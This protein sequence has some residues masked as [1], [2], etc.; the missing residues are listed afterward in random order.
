MSFNPEKMDREKHSNA[1]KAGMQRAKA[2]GKRTSKPPLLSDAQRWLLRR[3]VSEQAL[4]VSEAA[5]LFRV[6]QNTIRR[7]LAATTQPHC[8]STQ[9]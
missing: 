7:A 2:A 5:L 8:T 3:C 9:T 1:T 4:T 6:S